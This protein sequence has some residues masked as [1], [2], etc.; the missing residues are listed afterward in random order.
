MGE[1][2]ATEV[3]AQKLEEVG[4]I[5]GTGKIPSIDMRLKVWAEFQQVVQEGGSGSGRNPL[6]ALMASGGVVVRSTNPEIGNVPD[7]VMDT[8]AVVEKLR[9]DQKQ[10]I[11]LH[12]VATNVTTTQ[13]LERLAMSSTT[14]YRE[15][16]RIHNEM[17]FLLKAGKPVAVAKPSARDELLARKQAVEAG[18]QF[19]R[20]GAGD[21]KPKW[22][23]VKLEYYRKIES[24]EQ[25][26]EI[27]PNNHR[28]WNAQEVYPGRDLMLSGGYGKKHRLVRNITKAAITPDLTLLNVPE[29]HIDAVQAIYGDVDEW[30]VAYV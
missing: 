6:A 29:W 10:L 1:A 7:Y 21:F 19:I 3:L 24:G 14:F 18:V 11:W 28:G 13:K 22:T 12:Y 27:R 26:C 8:S 2:I 15:L 25:D 5:K 30:L 23:V 9:E 16:A 17:L 4:S 20:R